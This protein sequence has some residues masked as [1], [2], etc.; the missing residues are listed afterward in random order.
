MGVP[1][2]P[3]IPEVPECIANGEQALKVNNVSIELLVRTRYTDIIQPLVERLPPLSSFR[4]L[5]LMGREP[6]DWRAVAVVGNYKGE[7][8]ERSKHCLRCPNVQ[9]GY[10]DSEYAGSISAAL[11]G[12]IAGKCCLTNYCPRCT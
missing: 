7:P 5:F 6:G 9:K 2:I 10:S 12:F 3:Q 4:R 1:A 11:H 8:R